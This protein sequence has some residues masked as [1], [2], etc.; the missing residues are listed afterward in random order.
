MLTY[1]LSGGDAAGCREERPRLAHPTIRRP[2]PMS[3]IGVKRNTAA[4]FEPCRDGPEGDLFGAVRQVHQL[5]EK[6]FER[7]ANRRAAARLP[8]IRRLFSFG[9]DISR[10]TVR[11]LTFNRGKAV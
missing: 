2:A 10:L 4:R 7:R 5:A 6:F 1:L 3:V 11:Q 9:S 8:A